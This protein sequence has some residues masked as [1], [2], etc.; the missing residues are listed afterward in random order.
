M[1]RTNEIASSS[2][3]KLN[4]LEHLLMADPP[5]FCGVYLIKINVNLEPTSGLPP[6][7]AAGF[8]VMVNGERKP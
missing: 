4:L 6:I 8:F 7:A 1:V 5:Y 2:A 3:K